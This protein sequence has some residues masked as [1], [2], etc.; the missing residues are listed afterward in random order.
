MSVTKLTVKELRALSNYYGYKVVA[1][2]GNLATSQYVGGPLVPIMSI[3][4]AKNF[5]KRIMSIRKR[6]N[7]GAAW[8]KRK[9]Q[10][11][12]KKA[13][14]MQRGSTHRLYQ[15]GRADSHIES[16]DKS[17]RLRMNPAAKA[18]VGITHHDKPHLFT[19]SIRP[20]QVHLGA[21]Y[22]KV[23]GPFKSYIEAEQFED[24]L[25]KKHRM[26][27]RLKKNPELG[28]AT[29]E[30]LLAMDM[31]NE[32][33]AKQVR[34]GLSWIKAV[35]NTSTASTK[36]CNWLKNRNYE[37]GVSHKGSTKQDV[38]SF[39]SIKKNPVQATEIYSDI[40]AIEAKKGPNSLWPGEKFRHSFKKGGKIIGL[41]DGSLLIK[42]KSNKHRLWKNFDY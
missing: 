38:V 28:K 23:Y 16:F 26:N 39:R 9:A 42:P 14:L 36:F 15:I 29:N 1:S 4:Q 34:E 5:A 40:L 24:R 35:F 19:S 17:K 32:F 33:G 31:A 25:R 30:E 6:K 13:L 3:S 21:K 7:P 11:Y 22:L 12:G 27:P 8:H 10:E 41:D 18:Y 37:Y 2:K 20:S